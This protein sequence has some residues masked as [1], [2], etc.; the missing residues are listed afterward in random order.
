VG[1]RPIT[2]TLIGLILIVVLL[3]PFQFVMSRTWRR[4]GSSD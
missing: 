2:G 3:T 4:Q 1:T